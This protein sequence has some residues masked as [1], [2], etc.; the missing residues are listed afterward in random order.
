MF[1]GGQHSLARGADLIAPCP[2]SPFPFF[3]L[4]P[5]GCFCEQA[6]LGRDSEGLAV[7]DSRARPFSQVDRTSGALREIFVCTVRSNRG[8]ASLSASCSALHWPQK[9]EHSCDFSRRDE[10]SN[11]SGF[12]CS[13]LI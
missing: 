4:E 1:V 3:P 9:A 6:Y 12:Y 8:F 7:V 11:Y 13:R 10:S 5:T 2:T